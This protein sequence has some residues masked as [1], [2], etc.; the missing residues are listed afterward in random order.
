MLSGN[1][2]SRSSH[3]YSSLILKYICLRCA[4]IHTSTKVSPLAQWQ[5]RR[6]PRP[7]WK[8]CHVI[9]CL[10]YLNYLSLLYIQSCIQLYVSSSHI[11]DIADAFILSLS[12][13]I[14]G[15]VQVSTMD[16]EESPQPLASSSHQQHSSEQPT[17]ATCPSAKQ[18]VPGSTRSSTAS[19]LVLT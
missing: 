4:R 17:M 13:W 6:N 7:K 3:L 8:V 16:P 15:C 5:C 19:A 2:V 1:D 10:H 18:K 11:I 14:P 9:C 12:S